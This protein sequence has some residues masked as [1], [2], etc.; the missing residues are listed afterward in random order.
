MKNFVNFDIDNGAIKELFETAKEWTDNPNLSKEEFVDNLLAEEFNVHINFG[1]SFEIRFWTNGMFTDHNLVWD[2][3]NGVCTA[4][5][6]A[7]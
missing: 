5:Y 4:A 3:N 1:G 7:G 2:V 6:L